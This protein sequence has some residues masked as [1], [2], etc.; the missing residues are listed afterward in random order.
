MTELTNSY[1]QCFN[2]WKAYYPNWT[3]KQNLSGKRVKVIRGWVKKFCHRCYN[4]VNRNDGFLYYTLFERA[5]ILL[6][7]DAKKMHERN[8]YFDIDA[9]KDTWGKTNGTFSWICE[10]Y[11]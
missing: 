1:F 9:L 10:Y 11:L 6:Y 4:F 8:K 7:N 5:T 2:G 3:F